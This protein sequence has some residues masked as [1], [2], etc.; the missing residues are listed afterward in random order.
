MTHMLNKSDAAL[1]IIDVQQQLLKIMDKPISAQ[2]INN[3]NLFSQMFTYWDNPIIITEQYPKGL[4]PTCNAVKQH[5][6]QLQPVEKVT[7]GSC[8]DEG[9][10]QQLTALQTHK[11]ILVGMEAHVC[12]LQTALQLLQKNYQVIIPAD[13]VQS[14][15]KLRWKTGLNIAEKAGAVISNTESILFQMVERAGTDDFKQLLGVIKS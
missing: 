11:L 14:S 8:G 3:V 15:T 10:N 5:L 13:A 1:I 9:F 12:V 6:P 7:F 4:G 2:L